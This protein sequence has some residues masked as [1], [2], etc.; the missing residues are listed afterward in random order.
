MLRLAYLQGHRGGCGR[1]FI[2]GAS[3]WSTCHFIVTPCLLYEFLDPWWV[4]FF[5][6]CKACISCSSHQISS[7]TSLT[8]SSLCSIRAIRLL[9]LSGEVRRALAIWLSKRSLRRRW[10]RL[11]RRCRAIAALRSPMS[12]KNLAHLLQRLSRRRRSVTLK[13]RR[14]LAALPKPSLARNLAHLLR[15]NPSA[16][17]RS[18]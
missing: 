16:S 10:W 17:P 15:S 6:T 7:F 11:S 3:M 18:N 5:C 2:V 8:R 9:R 13:R 4:R 12:P 14:R 1:L